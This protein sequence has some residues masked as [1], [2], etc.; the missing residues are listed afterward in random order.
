[1]NVER[2]EAIS[3]EAHTIWRSWKYDQGWRLGPDAP[4]SMLSPLMSESYDHLDDAS[5]QW[6]RQ[7]TAVILG[8]INRTVPASEPLPDSRSLVASV[9]L[10]L[11][12]KDYDNAD[13]TSLLELASA[14]LPSEKLHTAHKLAKYGPWDRKRLMRILQIF[15]DE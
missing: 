13:V 6:F 1:M 8:A 15:M 14:S 11:E 4:A 7:M 3:R 10:K 2:I 5:K 9:L 12:E